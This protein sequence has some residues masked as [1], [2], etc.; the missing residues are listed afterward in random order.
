VS[1]E[2][3]LAAW[4]ISRPAALRPTGSGI[5]SLTF[6]VDTPGPTYCLKVYQNTS[7]PARVRAE[8][9]LLTALAAAGLPFAVPAPIRA[10]DGQT[11]VGWPGDGRLAALCPL[12]P[13]QPPDRANLAHARAVGQALGQLQAALAGIEPAASQPDHPSY[14]ALARIHPRVPDPLTAGDGLGLPDDARRRLV[15]ILAGLV[16]AVPALYARLPRQLCHC[17]YGPGQTLIAG[18][19][20]S[21]VLD[22]EFAGP[23]LRAIDVATGWY[24]S[25]S[26]SGDDPWPPIAAFAAG[27]RALVTATDAELAAAPTLARLQRAVGLVHWAGRLRAG[28]ADLP[29]VREQAERLL[30]VDDFATRH[31]PR[32]VDTLA[33]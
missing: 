5:N 1:V 31:G 29:L 21:G 33:G 7:D 20:I 27:Y 26:R 9:A 11:L 6:F 14:G 15:A 19:R 2:A 8:H 18:D 23:D 4:P 25:A 17:D 3:L 16:E 32:L 12:I 22:F 30:A 13:G 28:R 10:R 24:W